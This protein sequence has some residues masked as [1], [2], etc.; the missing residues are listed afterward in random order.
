M[1]ITFSDVVTS[2]DE[3]MGV[4]AVW[5]QSQA[6]VMCFGSR[7]DAKARD[8]AHFTQGRSTALKALKAPYLVTIGGGEQVPEPL[9]GRVLELVRVTGAY[10]ETNAFVENEDLS[11]RLAQWPVAVILSEVYRVEGEPLLQADLGFSDRRI[12]A[13]AYDSVRRDN[14]RIEQLYEA[15]ADRPVTRRWD[16]LPPPGFVDPGKLVLVSSIY[17]KLHHPN[18]REGRR[19]WKLNR[20]AERDRRLRHAAIQAN[21]DQNGGMIVCVACRLSGTNPSLFDVHHLLPL[22]AGDRQT[23]V[24]DLVVLCP[25]CHRCCHRLGESKFEPVP[26]EDLAHAANGAYSVL[27][28]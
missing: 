23:R 12:L 8:N 10:G 27:R 6:P 13:N 15:L 14:D 19:K 1:S 22:S 28:S 5:G 20:E 4:K 25:N 26:I 24:D 9:N 16:V 2:S 11:A 3:L 21:L 18:G 17:P 7:G